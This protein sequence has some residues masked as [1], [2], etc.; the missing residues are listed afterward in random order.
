MVDIKIDTMESDFRGGIV[1]SI[2][3]LYTGACK[4][5][6]LFVSWDGY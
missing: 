2:R 5:C 6:P 3:F 4:S 1:F